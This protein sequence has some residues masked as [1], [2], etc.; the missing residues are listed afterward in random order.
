MLG[1]SNF[2]SPELKRLLI[3]AK[4]KPVAN[5]IESHPHWPQN[6]LVKLFQDSGIHVTALGPLGCDPIK[7]MIGRT[8]PGPL[9]DETVCS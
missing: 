8:G 4:I 6:D 7:A 5:Q 1:V 3:S 9:E 2:S